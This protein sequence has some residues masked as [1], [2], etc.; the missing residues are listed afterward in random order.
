M[1]GTAASSF[2]GLSA[3]SIS[4]LR[5]LQAN[6][7]SSLNLLRVSSNFIGHAAIR[8]FAT[9]NSG[10]TVASVAA[11][12]VVSG[13]IILTAIIQYASVQT[14]PGTI[15]QIPVTCARSVRAG[16]FEIVT[17]ASYAPLGDMPVGWFKIA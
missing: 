17:V 9:I 1:A 7:V 4:T 10:T 6:N 14:L 3:S 5:D 15:G 16:A 13:D 2:T 11:T 8:G 12:G